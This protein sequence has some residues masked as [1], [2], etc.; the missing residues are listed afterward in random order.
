VLRGRDEF[1]FLQN[2]D[3]ADVVLGHE[4]VEWP[5]FD[6]GDEGGQRSRRDAPTP[7]LASDPV[8]HE[9]PSICHPTSNVSSHLAVV[10]DCADDVRVVASDLGPVDHEG[11]VVT[12]R[13][14][15]HAR[16]F[17]VALVLEEN[18][19][20]GVDDVAQNH[21]GTHA[22]SETSKCRNIKTSRRGEV[23]AGLA[24]LRGC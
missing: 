22:V 7:K 14:R 5:F 17:R 2:S 16:R 10:D 23:R 24:L 18:G 12:R 1:A 3:G 4:G 19:K 21:W 9:A 6:F 8:A 20:V 15:S 11:I 13:E